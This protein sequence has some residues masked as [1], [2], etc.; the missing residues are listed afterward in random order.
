MKYMEGMGDNLFKPKSPQGNIYAGL[1]LNDYVGIEAGYETT[2]MRT[3]GVEIQAGERSLGLSPMLP[4]EK[5]LTKSKIKGWHGAIIGFFP[6]VDRADGKLEAMGYIGTIRLKV[7][8]Q[9]ILFA[10]KSGPLN[11]LTTSRTFVSRKSLLKL[12]AGFQYTVNHTGFR[13]ML[14]YENSKRFNR[15]APNEN[16]KS[17][18]RLGIKNSFLMGIGFFVVI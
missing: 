15:M 14:G 18:K 10:N 17:Q 12:G 9:D 1:R 2:P 3:R 6:I 4:P 16:A 8:N 13:F 7:F 11:I 5:H